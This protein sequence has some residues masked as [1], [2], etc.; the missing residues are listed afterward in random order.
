[1]ST[2]KEFTKRMAVRLSELT[3]QRA[4]VFIATPLGEVRVVYR[5]NERTIADE[6]RMSDAVG[7]DAYREMLASME[8]MIVEW[9]FVGP[10]YDN[11]T[12][13]MIVDEDVQ[14]PAQKEIL[15]HISTHILQSVFTGIMEDMRPNSKKGSSSKNSQSLFASGSMS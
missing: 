4:E 13:A 7:V 6:A 8:K 15:Q 9:D 10:V 5:P 11:T 2:D 1:M 12:G 14:V 3:K